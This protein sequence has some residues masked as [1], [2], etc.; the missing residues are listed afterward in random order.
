M[1]FNT[2]GGDEM[3]GLLALICS[4]AICGPAV[5][6]DQ[7]SAF[8]GTTIAPKTF[9]QAVLSLNAP[10][11]KGE[12]E[13]TA[14]YQAR[15]AQAGS[16]GPLIISKKPEGSQYLEYDADQGA[17]AVK[18]YFFHNTNFP[19]WETFYH[20][21]NG[22]EASTLRNIDVTIASTD[23]A[24]GSYSGQ[25][26]FGAKATI[27]KITRT[28][29]AIYDREARYD[30]DLF[31]TKSSSLGYVP[32]SIEQAKVFKQQAKIA[33]LVMPKSPFVTRASFSYGKTTVSNPT[34][35]TVDATVLNADIQ[36][37][38]LTDAANKVLEAYPT[39]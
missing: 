2:L 10:T 39:R 36:C 16:S 9:D 33:F 32:M 13:T 18:S 7:C 28:V 30:E 5:A 34:D 1:D 4:M 8:K 19:A 21:K 23:V 26:G 3:K 37:A 35:V 38:F 15:L 12:F 17:F 27:T 11:P 22:V 14:A 20:A 29:K 6:Q 31:I 25:N 24:T